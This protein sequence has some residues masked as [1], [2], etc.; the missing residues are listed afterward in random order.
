MSSSGNPFFTTK[1][2]MKRAEDIRIRPEHGMPGYDPIW[3]YNWY[4]IGQGIK[5]RAFIKSLTPE[6]I[7]QLKEQLNATNGDRQV[8]YETLGRQIEER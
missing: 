3:E 7:N 2:E 6:Q 4:H 1:E 8:G 5:E